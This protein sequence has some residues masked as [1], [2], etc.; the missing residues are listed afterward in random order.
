MKLKVVESGFTVLTFVKYIQDKHWPN[1]LSQ[2]WIPDWVPLHILGYNAIF[3]SC[4]AE[5][6]SVQSGCP[7]VR[8]GL[9][10]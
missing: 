6:V 3:G 1:S 5:V 4:V 2:E 9:C 10:G 7:Q 8:S